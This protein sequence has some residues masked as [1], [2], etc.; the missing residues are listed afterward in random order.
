MRKRND[1]L[2]VSVLGMDQRTQTTFTYFLRGPCKNRAIVVSDESAEVYIIDVDGIHG[3]D[4]FVQERKKFPWRPIIVVSLA[5]P[6]DPQAIFVRKPVKPVEMLAA[7]EEARLILASPDS[8]GKESALEGSKEKDPPDPDIGS[9]ETVV[10]K[11]SRNSNKQ[12]HGSAHSTAMLLDDQS[13]SKFVGTV[14]DIDPNIQEQVLAAHYQRKDYLQAYVQSAIKLANSKNR[15]LTLNCGWKPITIFPHTREI[16]VDSDD[17]QLRAFCVLPIRSISNID[18]SDAKSGSGIS[19]TAVNHSEESQSHDPERFQSMDAFLWKLALWTSN[20][21]VPAGIELSYPVYLRVWPNLSR[22]VV[23]PHALRIA[24]LLIEKP[25]SLLDVAATLRIPQQYVF[26]FFSGAYAL[27]IAGQARRT[28]DIAV[29]PRPLKATENCG[30]LQ[31][32][33]SRLRIHL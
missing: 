31:K 29:A 30:L 5:S 2:R 19:V 4:L 21:R 25:R 22:L 24:A 7:L 6:D 23:I 18:M 11:R 15:I 13:Y 10:V 8:R 26:S 32:I 14:A 1:L 20:G 3:K 17:K 28:V 9:T 27:G 12:I 33:M 16:W